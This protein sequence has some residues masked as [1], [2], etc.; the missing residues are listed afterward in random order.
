MAEL[1]IFGADR[2]SRTSPAD[3]KA[4]NWHS[5]AFRSTKKTE[6]RIIEHPPVF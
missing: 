1:T 4:F 2:K 6:N 5:I 3:H